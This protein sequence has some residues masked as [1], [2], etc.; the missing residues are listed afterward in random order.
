L[1]VYTELHKEQLI[2][3]LKLYDIGNLISY[4]GI[5]EGIEN[6]NFFV[7]TTRGKFIIT[8][9]EN[10]VN[11]NEL[12]FFLEIMTH[13]SKK[14]FLCPYPIVDLKN[15]YIH[16]LSGKPSIIVNF[17]E[18]KSKINIRK[19]DCYKVG[20]Y[21]GY[22]H[23]QS[24][25]FPFERKN[26]LSIDGWK[27]LIH[28]CSESIPKSLLTDLGTNL[29]EDLQKTLY[30]CEK[31]W[32]FHLPK[33]FIHADMFPDNVFFLNDKISGV[34]DFYFSC[35]DILTYDLAIAVNAWCFNEHNV[36]D[37]QKYDSL[38]E[39]YNSQRKLNQDE[40]LYLPL[41]SQAASMRFLL[42]R[43]YDWVN[44]PEDADVIP[45]DPKEYIIKLKHFTN[46]VE[47]I[48]YN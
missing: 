18:G 19:K 34:I 42:T 24:Y 48:E 3:L 28:K 39:G 6:S 40:I 47:K 36:F 4:E 41:L 1:A 21:M 5:T 31:N 43:L 26:S 8:I 15:D 27:E 11:K 22:M 25:D 20:S 2:K 14:K 44:T 7:K 30:F 45:K 12:P 16:E 17:L 32:P 9:F 23:K 38:L 29:I 13:L 37:S 46:I 10:R 33:G 35:S